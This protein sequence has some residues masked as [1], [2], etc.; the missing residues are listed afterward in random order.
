MPQKISICIDT[1][2]LLKQSNL[3]QSGSLAHNHLKLCMTSSYAMHAATKILIVH[4]FIRS[5]GMQVIPKP[6]H[7]HSKHTYTCN[8]FWALH[9]WTQTYRKGIYV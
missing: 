7:T 5:A 4:C 3:Q 1:Y 6:C 2:V 9:L 8:S